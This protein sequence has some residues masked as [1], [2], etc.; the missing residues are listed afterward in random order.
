[1]RNSIAAAGQQDDPHARQT[2]HDDDLRR[3]ADQEEDRR[4]EEKEPLHAVH[5]WDWT[6]V[7][8]AAAAQRAQSATIL[9][10]I[11]GFSF[12]RAAR[13]MLS[14]PLISPLLAIT[15]PGWIAIGVAGV[16][17]FFIVIFALQYIGLWVQALVSGAKVS[18]INL[19]MM[20][21]RKVNPRV[22]VISPHQRE[23]GGARPAIRSS[24]SPLPRGRQRRATWCAP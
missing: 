21:F 13:K 18:F 6:G 22:I 12:E 11:A 15:T 20:R 24:R 14:S 17:V 9:H 19:V 8:L 10:L 23:E 3:R 5:S 4:A 16:I 2:E 7:N 1:M